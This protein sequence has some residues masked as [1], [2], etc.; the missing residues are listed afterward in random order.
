VR[1]LLPAFQRLP[2]AFANL[3]AYSVRDYVTACQRL[4]RTPDAAV[5]AAVLAVVQQ[6]LE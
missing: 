6:H 3:M 5:L 4:G 1:T 2:A